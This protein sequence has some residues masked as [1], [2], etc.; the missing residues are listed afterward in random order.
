M[1]GVSLE[2]KRGEVVAVVGPSGAGKSTLLD[3]MPR[4][5]D[6]QKGRITIDGHDIRTLSLASLRGLLGIVTQETYLFND[7][8]RHNI[9]YGLNGQATERVKEA[10]RMANAAPLT[11][12]PP[13]TPSDSEKSHMVSTGTGELPAIRRE[14]C[15]AERGTPSRSL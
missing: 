7:T 1:H 12:C 9:A 15:S 5:Y 2:V 10:A 4:F 11:T 8:I 14:L 13:R 6:P 3:L